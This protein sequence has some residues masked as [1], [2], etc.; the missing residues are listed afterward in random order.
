MFHM[1][2]ATAPGHRHRRRSVRQC[3]SGPAA[4]HA[5]PGLWRASV[6]LAAMRCEVDTIPKPD[7]LAGRFPA[8]SSNE[9]RTRRARCP[10]LFEPG[11][12]L[13]GGAVEEVV[14]GGED[15]FLLAA[16]QALDALQAFKQ[17]AVGLA[18]QGHGDRLRGMQ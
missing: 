2:R 9:N 5:A 15:G 12:A 6:A 18:L 11:P 10:A 13:S 14:D 3:G 1:T 8:L 16:G 4:K 7:G 17:P